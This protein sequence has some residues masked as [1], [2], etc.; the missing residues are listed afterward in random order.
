MTTQ[1]YFSDGKPLRGI[2][3]SLDDNILFVRLFEFLK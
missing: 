2:Y 1:F 3:K